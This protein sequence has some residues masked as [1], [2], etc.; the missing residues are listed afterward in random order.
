MKS[1]RKKISKKK[2]R[3]KSLHQYAVLA[4]YKTRPEDICT[5]FSEVVSGQIEEDEI[6]RN[7]IFTG[8]SIYIYDYVLKSKNVADVKKHLKLIG[9]LYRISEISKIIIK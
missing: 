8:E 6:F 2:S 4:Y 1:R 7:G 9:E 3:S 5:K